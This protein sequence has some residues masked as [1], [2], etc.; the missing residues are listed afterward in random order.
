M[1]NMSLFT[2]L[3]RTAFYTKTDDHFVATIKSS[4]LLYNKHFLIVTFYKYN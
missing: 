1:S 4:F 3:I 2:F